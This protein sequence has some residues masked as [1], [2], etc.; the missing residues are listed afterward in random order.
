M[1]LYRDIHWYEIVFFIQLLHSVSAKP[2]VIIPLR[3]VRTVSEHYVW[4]LSEGTPPINISLINSS[5]TLA[6]GKGMVWSKIN[7]DGNYSCIATN[8]NGTD[9]K[10]F[11]VSVIDFHVCVN[12]CDCASTVDRD[13]VK[14]KFHCTGKHS[15]DILNNIPTT[16]TDL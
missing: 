14:N 7:Q 1:K 9:S 12:L 8:D 13:Q 4:C 3:V 6:F 10:T 2:R 15:A 5:T 16:T 11:Y